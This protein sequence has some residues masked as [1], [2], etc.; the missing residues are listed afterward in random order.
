M[1]PDKVYISNGYNDFHSTRSGGIIATPDKRFNDALEYVCLPNIWRSPIA[2]PDMLF[3]PILILKSNEFL[4]WECELLYHF[5]NWEQAVESYP[6]KK[7]A[8]V[9][10]LLPH[11]KHPMMF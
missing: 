5:S 4:P 11:E 7:W 1:I 8:Y 3:L 6:I 2:K 9:H 10:N